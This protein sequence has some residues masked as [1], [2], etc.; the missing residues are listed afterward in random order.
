VRWHLQDGIGKPAPSIGVQGLSF[1]PSFRAHTYYFAESGGAMPEYSVRKKRCIDC[2]RHKFLIDFH[3]KKSEPDGYR[4][5]C[6]ECG[7]I[8]WLKSKKYKQLKKKN[9]VHPRPRGRKVTVKTWDQ[10][11]NEERARFGLYV[12]PDQ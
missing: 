11:T 4:P 9:R 6:L 5:F 12:D 1:P 2:K 10:L 7:K 8:R 3:R